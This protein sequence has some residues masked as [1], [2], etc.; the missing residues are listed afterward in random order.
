[1]TGVRYSSFGWLSDD[2]YR[3]FCD[4]YGYDILDWAGFPVYRGIRELTMTTW[5][6]Q[7]VDDQRARKEFHHRVSEIRS[8][9]FP[10]TWSVF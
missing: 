4:A 8:G 3:A 2:Q 10:R 5:L 9:R 7:L 1:M 6:M